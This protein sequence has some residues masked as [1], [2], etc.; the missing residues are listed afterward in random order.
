MTIHL[1]TLI[2]AGLVGLLALFS[3][4]L[5]RKIKGLDRRL[6][7]LTTTTQRLDR[8]LAQQR[9][10][11]AML[12]Q[13]QQGEEDVVTHEDQATADLAL[14]DHAF[15]ALDQIANETKAEQ[16]VATKP[17]G[18][19]N[20]AVGT[21]KEDEIL[22]FLKKAIKSNHVAVSCQPIKAL[23]SRET[24]FYEIY[25]RVLVGNQGYI[26]AN[27]F[28]SI[29]RDHNLMSMV[30]NLLLLRCLQL[31]KQNSNMEPATGFFVNISVQ[32]LGNKTYVSDLISFLEANP[33]LSS[34]L[35]FEITQKDS[36]NI[37]TTAKSVM[38]GL[39]LLGCRF[40][41]DQVSVFGID[42][43]RLIDQ[44]ISFVKLDV[45]ALIK[46][47]D[48]VSALKRLKRIKASLEAGGIQVIMEK[49]ENEKQL[50]TLLDL[51]IDYA[52]GYLF[53]QPELMA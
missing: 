26:P 28:I 46:E 38:E 20:V 21:L 47:M 35:I 44:N 45:R 39:A 32:T 11:L 43:N 41:M 40:S 12:R 34:R 37:S 7:Q 23:P 10:A 15:L 9:Y 27:Q 18:P 14:M 13:I 48:D 36:I 4:F 1:S 6:R 24:R 3:I 50:F 33:R 22:Q 31:V 25:A 19:A 52:Q 8:E 30:D 42:I 53:G 49:V 2:L 17:E 5:W 29:A 51:Y 16:A